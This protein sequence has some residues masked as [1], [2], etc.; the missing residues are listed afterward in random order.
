MGIKGEEGK[1]KKKETIFLGY[2][3]FYFVIIA[4]T[5]WKEKNTFIGAVYG[6]TAIPS[7]DPIQSVGDLPSGSELS[8]E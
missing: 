8:M 3:G 5:L 7:S 4:I 1:M 6:N 2:Y